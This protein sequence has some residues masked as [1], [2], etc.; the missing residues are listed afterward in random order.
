MSDKLTMALHNAIQA[1]S[2]VRD[3][4]TDLHKEIQSL[5]AQR[6]LLRHE[7]M[8]YQDKARDAEERYNKIKSDVKSAI[9]NLSDAA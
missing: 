6:D 4:I 2:E 9:S 7:C 5:T 1:L 8:A 3:K